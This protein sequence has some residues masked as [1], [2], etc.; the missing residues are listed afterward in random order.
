MIATSPLK[1]DP[2]TVVLAGGIS[3]VE[4]FGCDRVSRFFPFKS[5]RFGHVAAFI[6]RNIPVNCRGVICTR[7]LLRFTGIFLNK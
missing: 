7:V 4:F 3:V 1:A 2:V 5:A 6:F